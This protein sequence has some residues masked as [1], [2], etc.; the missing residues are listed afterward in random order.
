[1]RTAWITFYIGYHPPDQFSKMRTDTEKQFRIVTTTTK[2]LQDHCTALATEKGLTPLTDWK[3]GQHSAPTWRHYTRRFTNGYLV[4]L[5]IT[6]ETSVLD[7]ARHHQHPRTTGYCKACDSNN[8]IKSKVAPYH[9]VP[10]GFHGSITAHV[11]LQC[12]NF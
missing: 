5:D 7:I 9:L 4:N 12:G 6:G 11:C 10:L 3:E 8:R 2:E 1:M